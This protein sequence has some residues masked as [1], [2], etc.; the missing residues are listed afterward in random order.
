VYVTLLGECVD[1]L[2]AAEEFLEQMRARPY[3]PLLEAAILQVRKSLELVAIAAIA[4]DQKQYE[5][6]RAT[7]TKDPDFTKDYHA[8]KIFAALAR[9]NPDFYPKPLLPAVRTTDGTWHYDDKKSGVLSKRQ[10]AN[11]YDRLG[12][13]LHAHNPWG[14]NKFLDQIVADLPIIILKSRGLIALHARLIRT[15]D[16]QG[17]W[18]VQADT[19]TPYVITGA[20]TGPYVVEG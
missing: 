4:P 14:S 2:A 7:A 3:A 19:T 5:A 8:A 13:Y 1:R 12:K 15:R 18:I 16:F 10:F 11:T 20:A 17:V 9:I 6:F